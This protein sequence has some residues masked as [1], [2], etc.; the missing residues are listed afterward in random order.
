MRQY[1]WHGSQRQHIV[2]DCGFA[3]QALQRG[4]GGL[5]AH[6][7]ALA[8]K[9]IKKRGFFAA[10]ICTRAN[11]DFHDKWRNQMRRQPDSGFHFG[12]G[13]RIFRTDVDIAFARADGETGNRHA[14]DQHERVAF[15]HHPVGK[16]SAVAFIGVADDIFLFSRGVRH[17][18]PLNASRKTRAAAAA[19]ARCHYGFDGCFRANCACLAK[20]Q[21]ATRCVIIV[22]RCRPCLARARKRQP[23]LLGDKG[24]ILN[25]SD[26]FS[27]TA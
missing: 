22:Q 1:P 7:A 9:A 20:T 2:D 25:P 4:Q 5:G 17:R 13:V 3:K 21:P 19:K 14:F 10:N 23:A 8:L 16:G 11:A 6:F 18:P 26:G 15:H 27:V 12:N 24:V